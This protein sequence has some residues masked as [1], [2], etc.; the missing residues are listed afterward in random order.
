MLAQILKDL[1]KSQQQR[2]IHPDF[3]SLVLVKLQKTDPRPPI[4]QL[5]VIFDWII[6]V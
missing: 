5:S 6:L 4:M 2:Q 3:Y 1:S